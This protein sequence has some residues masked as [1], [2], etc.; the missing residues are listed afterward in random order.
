M[1]RADRTM[2]WPEA[3]LPQEGSPPNSM[4]LAPSDSS[5]PLLSSYSPEHVWIRRATIKLH[6][7]TMHGCFALCC[8]LWQFVTNPP[9]IRKQRR[10]VTIGLIG[11]Q[12]L[13]RN[14]KW[15]DSCDFLGSR[16]TVSHFPERLSRGGPPSSPR[17]YTLS[18]A[19]HTHR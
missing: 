18:F 8:S 4:Q 7:L 1:H 11:C 12:K 3:S 13:F 6:M 19:H 16:K 5:P 17:S 14:S 2:C 10:T 15:T 9:A